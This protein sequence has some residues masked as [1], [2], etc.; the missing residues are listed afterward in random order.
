M[1]KFSIYQSGN[2]H[3][4][5]STRRDGTQSISK[6]VTC[7][8]PIEEGKEHLSIYERYYSTH[9][10]VSQLPENSKLIAHGLDEQKS[11]SM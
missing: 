2:D 3:Y 5:V 9:E 11:L 1:C 4:H 10:E 7:L 6:I 8:T